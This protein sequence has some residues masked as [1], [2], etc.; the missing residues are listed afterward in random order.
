MLLLLVICV[1]VTSTSA[2]NNSVSLID[3][4]K[5][6]TNLLLHPEPGKGSVLLSDGYFLYTNLD[7]VSD[8][9][10]A[11][12]PKGRK[13]YSEIESAGGIQIYKA[14]YDPDVVRE[15]FQYNADD[16]EMLIA[17]L[18]GIE[19]TWKNIEVLLNVT[20]AEVKPSIN[21]KTQW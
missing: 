21:P 7:D 12:N 10:E 3:L 15:K 16:Y 17:T 18:G 13:I 19:N 14:T 2:F 9:I 8:M 6:L 11:N 1:V 20:A 4:D 5:R